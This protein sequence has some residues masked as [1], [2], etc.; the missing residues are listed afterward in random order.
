MVNVLFAFIRVELM[1]VYTD[2]MLVKFFVSE[3]I[4]GN[5]LKQWLCCAYVSELHV[6]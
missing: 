5:I 3:L 2:E 6:I 4:I 1:T